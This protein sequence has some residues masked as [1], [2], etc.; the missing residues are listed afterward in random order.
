M[1]WKKLTVFCQIHELD[2]NLGSS[3][4]YYDIRQKLRLSVEQQVTMIARGGFSSPC[5]DCG[6]VRSRRSGQANWHCF[7]C[8]KTEEV[9]REPDSDVDDELAS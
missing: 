5:P 2:P 8:G 4:D 6:A 3:Q 7:Y 1:Y 9:A